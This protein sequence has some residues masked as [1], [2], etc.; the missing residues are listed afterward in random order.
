MFGVKK[1][2]AVSGVRGGRTESTSWFVTLDHPS[3]LVSVFGFSFVDLGQLF[4]QGRQ[5][6]MVL[7]DRGQAPTQPQ[8]PA[9]PS[10]P[11]PL[12]P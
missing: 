5:S 4:P 2:W 6:Q 7:G 9:P 3:R 1:P 11:C 12:W 10:P 8:A